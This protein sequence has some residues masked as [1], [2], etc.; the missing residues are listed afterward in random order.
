MQDRLHELHD[1][2]STELRPTFAEPEPFETISLDEVKTEKVR[3]RKLFKKK[4]KKKSAKKEELYVN[5]EEFMKEFFE[6]VTC[7]KH[8][9]EVIDKNT[10]ELEEKAGRYLYAP[11]ANEEHSAEVLEKIIEETNLAASEVRNRLKA[12]DEANERTPEEE[13]PAQ[14]KIRVNTYGTL[15]KRFFELGSRYQEVQTNYKNKHQEKLGHFYKIVNPAAT[16]EE[17]DNIVENGNMQ[18]LREMAINHTK[19]KETLE[20]VTTQ[21][22]EMRMLEQSIKELQQLFL[23]MALLVESSQLMLDHIESNVDK[24]SAYVKDA[25]RDL[26]KAR[27]YKGKERKK[28]GFLIVGIIAA[29]TGVFGSLFGGLL[30]A[31]A[32]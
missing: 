7:I 2:N 17:V 19:A 31:K 1:L 22:K 3:K 11:A 32:L 23:D 14:Y 21:N 27:K 24:S 28:K 5:E 20:F 4:S 10:N 12:M 25:T 29:I 16:Q 6:E 18:M 9:F 8:C 30:G 26:R 13:D 15:V